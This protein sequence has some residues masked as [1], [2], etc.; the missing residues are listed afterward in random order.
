MDMG[1][2]VEEEDGSGMA[3]LKKRRMEREKAQREATSLS[4]SASEDETTSPQYESQNLYHN[5]KPKRTNTM[6]ST[7]S[8]TTIRNIQ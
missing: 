4:S 8:D 1:D 3:W 2:E 6:Q 7:S 5:L